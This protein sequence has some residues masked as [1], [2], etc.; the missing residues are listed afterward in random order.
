LNVLATE[1]QNGIACAASG[2][3]FRQ[4]AWD[5]EH[6]EDGPVCCPSVHCRSMTATMPLVFSRLTYA[7]TAFW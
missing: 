2:I 6:P 4:V 1:I 7:L 5:D 3:G